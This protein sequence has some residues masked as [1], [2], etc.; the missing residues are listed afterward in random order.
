MISD[1][2]Q[3]RGDDYIETHTVHVESLQ[4]IC[5]LTG[6]EAI[7]LDVRNLKSHFIVVKDYCKEEFPRGQRREFP[8]GKRQDF[9]VGG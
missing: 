5:G 2:M 1:F 3:Q 7:I 6:Q 9:G 4:Q 8:T